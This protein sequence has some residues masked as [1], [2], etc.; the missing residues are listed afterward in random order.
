[1]GTFSYKIHLVVKQFKVQCKVPMSD[2]LVT[3][4]LQTIVVVKFL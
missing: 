2:M 4:A 3:H 1:M